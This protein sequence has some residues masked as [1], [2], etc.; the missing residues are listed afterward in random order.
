MTFWAKK[1]EKYL[2]GKYFSYYILL[3]NNLLLAPYENMRNEIK[4]SFP[5]A[6]KVGTIF[7]FHLFSHQL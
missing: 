3:I 6:H 5:V 7:S 2:V 4:K 1:Y